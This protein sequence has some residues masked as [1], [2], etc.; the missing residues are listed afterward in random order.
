[1]GN[2]KAIILLFIANAIS[3][4]A[5]GI[6][7]IAI[8]WYFAQQ[9]LLGY[10]VL[11]YLFTNVISLFWVPYSGTLIDRYDRKHVFL[12]V[13]AV[14]GLMLAAITAI[15]FSQGGL[16]TPLIALVFVF[17]F[18]NY[19]IHYPNVYAFVQ[20]ITESK[21]YSRITS[22]ME[23]IGQITTIT[24]GAVSTLLLVG[25]TDGGFQIFGETL[26]LGTH[27][28]PWAIHEIFLVDACTY[29][30]A[31][32]IIAMISYVPLQQRKVETGS[33]I[34][35]IQ[36]GWTYLMAHKNVLSYGVLSYIVFLA[37][38]M[39][40]FYLGVSY[41]SNHLQESGDVYANSKMAYSLGAICTGIGL[42][43]LFSRVS[44]PLITIILTIGTAAIFFTQYATKSTTLFFIMLFLLGI[45]NAGTRIARVTYLFR[46]VPNQFFGRAGSIFF[47]S[48]IIFRILLLSLFSLP[49]FQLDNNVTYAYLVVSIVLIIAVALLI[50]NYK[51]YDL[52]T[53]A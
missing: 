4:I 30:A 44:I 42:K 52:S 50:K 9:E 17:T 51:T 47:M 8:P 25:T 14:G 45:T 38:L 21:Y 53:T 35:R 49:F 12:A 37:M 34:T 15:G 6:S 7:M 5:Q 20:E 26:S 46:N 31:F 22:Y 33:M 29:F 32:L 3:G 28:S 13:T 19:N 39:E 23:I 16:A 48:N 24:A 18:L 40:A 10:F 41:V 2:T 36:L 43:Y 11:V 1:M 27:I